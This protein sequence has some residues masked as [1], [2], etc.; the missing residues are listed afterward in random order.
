V[1]VA[2]VLV[3]TAA[4]AQSNQEIGVT[5]A[6]NPNATGTPPSAE[7]RILDVGVNVFANEKIVTTANGQA[8]MLFMDESAFTVGPNSEVV[9]DEFVYD[10]ETGTGKLALTATKGVF[11]FVGGKISKRTPVTLKTPTAVIG[12]RGGIALVNVQPNGPTQATFLFGDQM[13]VASAGVTQVARR[14]GFAITADAPDQA[15]SQPAPAPPEQLNAALNSL[16]RSAPPPAEGGGQGQPGGQQGQQQQGQQQQQQQQAQNQQGDGQQG[17]N[18]QG[19]N[20]QGGQQGDQQG[21][22]Q[23]GGPQ[24]GGGRRVPTDQDVAQTS[25]G[26]QGSQRPPQAIAAPPIFAAIAPP[27]SPLGGGSGTEAAS[28]TTTDS[29]QNN[30]LQQ[31]LFPSASDLSGRYKRSL[32]RATGTADQGSTTNIPFQGGAFSGGSFSVPLGSS[33]LKFPVLKA[34][35]TGIVSASNTSSPFGTFTGDVFVAS[36]LDFL[37]VEGVE[38]G[39]TTNRVVAFAGKPSSSVPTSGASFYALQND[40]G[41]GSSV[42]FFRAVESGGITVPEAEG[43]ADAAIYWDVS[44]S[45]TAQRPFGFRT[46]AIDGK[47]TSQKSLMS[48]GGGAV[49]FDS[50]NRPFIRGGSLGTSRTTLTS[51]PSVVDSEL[52]SADDNLGNDFFGTSGSYFVLESAQV[53][54]SDGQVSNN[55]SKVFR[56]GQ[57]PQTVNYFPTVVAMPATTTLGTRTTRTL[58]GYLGGAYQTEVSGSLSTTTMFDGVNDTSSDIVMKTSATTNKVQATFRFQNAFGTGPIF[59]VKFGDRD[60]G[61]FGDSSTTSGNGL[62]IDDTAMVAGD[63]DG[64]GNVTINSTA[65]NNSSVAFVSV[66]NA[67]EFSS[68]FLPSGVSVCSCKYLSWGFWG[69][70]ISDTTSSS[71]MIHMANYVTGE[72]ANLASISALQGTATYNGHAIGT[73]FTNSQVY[74]AIGSVA[75]TVNFDSPSTSTFAINNFDNANYSGTGLAITADGSAHKFTGSLSG[76]GRTGSLVG[77]FM[78][79]GGSAAAE[80]G[81]QFKVDGG[82]YS[83]VG[84]FA[85]AK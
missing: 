57:T 77:S 24:A 68:N 26:Q 34:G 27:L 2:C 15:P 51:L 23:Q 35:T 11:R 36:T 75:A 71:E 65:Q 18:Q 41:L 10:P 4:L 21:N 25:L 78:S 49:R 47:G 85:A 74:Q 28:D 67:N 40:F 80:M 81:G 84:I 33:T 69:G 20:Q 54:L 72:I 14:P 7:T 56:P 60:V 17:E 42:P 3:S 48:L 32:T 22:G 61:A 76:V 53:D 13:T 37:F 43:T 46:I 59:Q 8:Q 70:R 58:G 73:V 45:S 62:F 50:Q 6:L 12:I 82:G 19:D 64:T 55:G 1:L 83:A 30:T 38:T 52:S 63:Q 9:L 39:N 66:S 44:G 16:E 29:Q 31:N 5:A 79:G